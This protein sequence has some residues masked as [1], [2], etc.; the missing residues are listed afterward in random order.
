MSETPFLFIFHFGISCAMVGLIWF[1]QVV[2]YPLFRLVGEKDHPSH[3][4]S[5]MGRTGIVVAPIM[6]LELFSGLALLIIVVDPY[7]VYGNFFQH[8]KMAFASM[9]CLVL[10]WLSTFLIQVPCH[11]A[12]DHGKDTKAIERLIYSNWLR[13]LLW[14]ARPL[15]LYLS[16]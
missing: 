10:I 12:L 16:L 13:T 2:H 5:H 8:P 7:S 1:V 6:L 14:T 9:I 3:H 11:R 4:A 15:L